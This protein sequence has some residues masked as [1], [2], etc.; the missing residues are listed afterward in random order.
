MRFTAVPLVHLLSALARTTA[1]GDSVE[2]L[3]HPPPTGP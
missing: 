1:P 2:L 3:L